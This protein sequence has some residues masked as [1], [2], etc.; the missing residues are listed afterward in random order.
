[1]PNWVNQ[2]V[3]ISGLADEIAKVK[4]QVSGYYVR[5]WVEKKYNDETKSWEFVELKGKVEKPVFSF[6]NIIKPADEMLDVYHGVTNDDNDSLIE[7]LSI[8]DKV[9]LELATS[10][11]WYAWNC[12]NW[13]SKWD[14]CD[15]DNT[16]D[17]PTYLAYV[18]NTA[19]SPSL[20][21][22]QEL[23]RQYPQLTV[24]IDYEEEQGWGGERS[25]K[26][27]DVV[28]VIEYDIPESHA[29]VEERGNECYC[30]GDDYKPFADCPTA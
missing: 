27:G 3:T 14:A 18:Y 19:W 25:Y 2:T 5:Q 11:G 26:G 21:A 13:G 29:E 4:E 7:G 8:T 10:N 15:V 28:G 30:Y 22:I 6:W 12:R 16:V 24:H 9:M 20:E 23:S 17:E 1:M